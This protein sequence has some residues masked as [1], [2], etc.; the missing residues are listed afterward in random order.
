MFLVC[1][2]TSGTWVTQAYGQAILPNLAPANTGT[3]SA[4]RGPNGTLASMRAVT[5][6][7]ASEINPLLGATNTIQSFGF[8]LSTPSTAVFGGTVNIYLVNTTDVVNNKGFDWTLAL[9]GT[10]TPVTPAMTQVCNNCAFSVP[11]GS[12]KYDITLGTPFA[13][14]GAGVYVAYDFNVTT[15]YVASPATPAATVITNLD[16]VGV[17]ASNQ[18]A[19]ASN[20]LGTALSLV[21]PE[22]RFGTINTFANDI[23]VVGMVAPGKMPVGVSLPVAIR[24][25]IINRSL[26]SK[27][28]IPVT[29]TIGAFTNTQTVTGP[30][31]PGETATVT[32]ANFT[33]T[34]V[35]VAP[36]VVSVLVTGDS[37]TPNNSLSLGFEA[38]CGTFSAAN[39]GPLGSNNGIGFGVG[40]GV[41]LAKFK[42]TSNVTLT[43]AKITLS[44][45]AANSGNIVKGVVTDL[46]GN[47]LAVSADYTILATDVNT[48]KTFTFLVPPVITANT[49]FLVGL[50][51]TAAIGAA[52]QPLAFQRSSSQAGFLPLSNNIAVLDAGILFGTGPAPATGATTV[53]GAP[54]AQTITT[55]PMIDVVIANIVFTNTVA[56]VAT[57]GV[58]YS[59][60]AGA[61][62]TSGII[63]YS[64]GTPSLP[65]GLSINATTGL[66]S[67]TPTVGVAVPSTAYTVTAT[68][69]GACSATQTYTFQVT[70]T[71]VLPACTPVI[72]TPLLSALNFLVG[73]AITP[74]T[75][76]A[77][78]GDAGVTYAYTILTGTGAPGP[79]PAGLT[80]VAGVISGT[81]TGPVGTSGSFTVV[82]TTTPR[83]CVGNATYTYAIKSACAVVLA[84]TGLPEGIVGTPY[85]YTFVATGGVGATYEFT[86]PA[87]LPAGLTLNTATGVLSGTPTVAA[88]ITLLVTAKTPTP[89]CSATVGYGLT[90][91]LNSITS[92]DNSLANLVK[93]SPNPSKGDFNIDFSTINMAKSS[94]RVYDAQGKVVFTSENNSNLM[95]ISLDKFANGIY[96]MEVETSKGRVLKRLAKQ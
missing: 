88:S 83:S 18:G 11:I 56:T 47:I 73:V 21:R 14:T 38:T 86:T 19:V 29:V 63:T 37:Y 78:G 16:A 34:V 62:A 10:T 39:S 25:T 17:L 15:T 24:A 35:G 69:P 3:A 49:D 93:V 51:Q 89:T 45:A 55:R 32:F 65:A 20:V 79:L 40:G 42:A 4:L 12:T 67:G 85:T 57:A 74:V 5:I 95:T 23:G 81:P 36:I 77:S 53:G 80:L 28:G 82:A 50:W 59:L 84:A 61:T 8:G 94:V 43:S 71:T 90:V 68:T 2:L 76:G 13:Y 41:L 9:A 91:R 33:P 44:D 31:L 48:Q 70:S 66:I 7:R 58:P 46:A 64:V 26:T 6:V 96:L 1:L 75:L 92:I 52:Y 60:N 72:I 30:V 54:G 87:T 22:F 27:S